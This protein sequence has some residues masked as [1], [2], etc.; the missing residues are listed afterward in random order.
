MT[1]PT[2]KGIQDKCTCQ[3]SNRPDIGKTPETVLD[4]NKYFDW[5]TQHKKIA[6]DSCIADE[7]LALWK[8]GIWTKGSCCGHNDL[9]SRSIILEDGQDAKKAISLVTKAT[10]LKQWQL[11][12]LGKT[13]TILWRDSTIINEQTNEV[14]EVTILETVGHLIEESG[15]RVTIA[16]DKI[17]LEYRGVI[18]IPKENILL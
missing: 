17:G 8:A 7:V 15:D 9:N 12:D 6:V 3:S 16:R 2:I 4:P 5:N 11:V 10:K 1:T 14:P 18:S 13:T